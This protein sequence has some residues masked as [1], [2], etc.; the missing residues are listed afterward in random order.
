MLVWRIAGRWAASNRAGKYVYRYDHMPPL[1]DED[2]DPFQHGRLKKD[3]YFKP[4][5]RSCWIFFANSLDIPIFGL[6]A[7]ILPSNLG[8][9]PVLYRSDMTIECSWH[10]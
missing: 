4:I 8:D 10:Q 7:E 3:A 5:S 1:H 2:Q 6:C 9:A